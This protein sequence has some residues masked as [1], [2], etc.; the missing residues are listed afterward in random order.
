MID[1]IRD[2][3]HGHLKG[4]CDSCDL[5]IAEERITALEKVAELVLFYGTHHAEL[6]VALR[7]A[8]YLQEQSDE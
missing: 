8:S 6:K 1:P 2:C 4:K 7:A 5:I 3:P